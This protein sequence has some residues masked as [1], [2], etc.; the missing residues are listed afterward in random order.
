MTGIILVS[1]IYAHVLFD[2]SATYSFISTTFIKEHDMLFEPMATE[3]YI[4]TLVGGILSINTIC[5][6]NRIRIGD[7]VLFADLMY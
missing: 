6:S 3:L 2:S 7:R 5:K 4:G 1:S